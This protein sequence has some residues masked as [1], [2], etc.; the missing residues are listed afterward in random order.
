MTEYTITVHNKSEDF[1][2]YL[3]FASQPL[4]KW[5]NGEIFTNIYQV[6]HRIPSPHGSTVFTI[7]PAPFAVCGTLP[8]PLAVGVKAETEDYT[9]VILGNK[10]TP[11]YGSYIPVSVEDDSPSFN[12]PLMKT[13]VITGFEMSTTAFPYPSP[14]KSD[15]SFIIQSGTK[16]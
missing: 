4:T 8:T 1:Q 3:L 13:T 10:S 14:S 7:N 2:T 9:S 11:V 12:L 15:P 16:Q 6:A 5:H